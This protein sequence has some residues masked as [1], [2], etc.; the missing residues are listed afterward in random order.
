MKTEEKE[1][2]RQKLFKARERYSKRVSQLSEDT[3]PVAP[4][5]SIGRVS[6]MDAINN[7]SVS[8]AA[9]ANARDKLRDVE[10]SL[11][12]IDTPDFGKCKSCTTPIPINRLMAMPESLY[13]MKCV[14]K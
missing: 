3:A 8:E 13:C 4:D 7:K 14:R 6:R 12:R 11:A 1:I 10:E 2:I 5:C 9:L